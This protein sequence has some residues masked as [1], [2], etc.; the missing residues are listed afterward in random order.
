[1]V[2]NGLSSMWR[3]IFG[4]SRAVGET[5]REL[6][7]AQR[8]RAQLV[9]EP[10]N[11]PTSVPITMTA[12]L[13]QVRA[14]D[15][16]V[17]Q[18]ASGGVTRQLVTGEPL[19]LSVDLGS[20]GYLSGKTRVLGRAKVSSGGDNP[21]FGYRLA[22]PQSLHKTDRRASARQKKKTLDLAREAELYRLDDNEPIRGI[23]QNVSQ[24]GMQILRYDSR[25]RLM[26]GERVRLVVYL[27]QPVGQVNRMVTV[28]R[29]AGG[30]NP[31]QP[32]IGVAFERE[33]TGLAELIGQ[34][35]SQ[36]AA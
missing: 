10:P 34:A 25:R 6:R 15:L 35:N 28:A 32:I 4:E 26:K 20:R 21:I 29:I 27:P 24:G 33:V 2:G 19:T 17:S 31:R 3:A 22:L 7:V 5:R 13:E 30:R 18:P 36:E 8:T 11:S 12:T 1:M 23:V 16:V 14:K 9:L